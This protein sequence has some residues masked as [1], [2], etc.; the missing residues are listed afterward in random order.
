MQTRQQQ[1][2]R[3]IYCQVSKVDKN[4]ATQYAR[5]VYRFP[6]LVRINGLQQTLG[7][8]MGKA[9]SDSGEGEECFLKHLCELLRGVDYSGLD[10]KVSGME[11]EEYLYCSRRC[12]E[13]S[14]WYRRFV[15]SVLKV[16]ITSGGAEASQGV[17]QEEAGDD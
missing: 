15:E 10:H 5:A 7:F 3:K 17:K 9:A 8:Y 13:V 11:L 2:A 14:I 4:L 16:D 12:L 6:L 1:D